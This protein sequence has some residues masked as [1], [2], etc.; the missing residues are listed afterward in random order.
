MSIIRCPDCRGPAAQS[1]G[2][3]RHRAN[4]QLSL[5]R[6]AARDAAAKSARWPISDAVEFFSELV[7]EGN[8]KQIADEV[9]KEIRGRLGFLL[10]VGLE[11][12]SLERTAPTLSGG[13]SQRIRLAG[14][15]GCGLVGV[16]YILDEP[17]IGLH[18]R[19]NDRLLD[20]LA[21]LRDLGNT[22]VVVE[23]DEDTMRAADHIIDFGPGPGVRGGEVVASGTADQIA[24]EPRSLTG[25]FLSGKRKIEV[26][27]QRRIEPQGTNNGKASATVVACHRPR[28]NNLKNIDVDIQQYAKICCCS[29]DSSYC[30]TSAVAPLWAGL[31]TLILRRATGKPRL[32]TPVAVV[33]GARGVPGHHD[34][35]QRGV[36]RRPRLGRLHGLGESDRHGGAI[37][38]LGR[39]SA[40]QATGQAARE[41][42]GQ[43]ARE[44]TGQTAREATGQTAR[45]TTG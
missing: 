38:A 1:A 26:P 8:E 29:S 21:E 11:Y 2:V 19:D 41:A 40:G 42:T 13:E 25:A 34:R 45:E 16:L 37:D 39:W 6:Q 23:H 24:R 18:P 10:N 44:A 33:P 43:T 31:V 28:H 7:L 20:T 30:W 9:L 32:A 17:S 3:R 27:Q 36:R 14:Q 22:V 15:I 12:L 5:R 4:G 35:K